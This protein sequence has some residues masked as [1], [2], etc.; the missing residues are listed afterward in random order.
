MIK[1][2]KGTHPELKAAIQVLT[3]HDDILRILIG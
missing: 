3:R 1:L 2:G